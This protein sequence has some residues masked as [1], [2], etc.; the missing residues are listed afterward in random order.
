M[1]CDWCEKKIG[2]GEKYMIIHEDCET[3]RNHA[4]NGHAL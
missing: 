3:D 1:K 2:K 4:L